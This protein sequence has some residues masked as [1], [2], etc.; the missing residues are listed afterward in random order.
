MNIKYFAAF[1][2][3]GVKKQQHMLNRKSWRPPPNSQLFVKKIKGPTWPWIMIVYYVTDLLNEWV[4]N[5]PSEKI[6]NRE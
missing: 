1:S 6:A 5:S 3:D 2:K 4:T